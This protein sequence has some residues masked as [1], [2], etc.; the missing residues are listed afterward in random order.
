VNDFEKELTCAGI[1]DENGAVD[2]LGRQ[3]A[4]KGLVDCDSVH[5]RVINKP[6]EK[7]LVKSQF[8]C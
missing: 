5:I 7:Y 1:E 8:N 2:G 6:R 3:V 4:L